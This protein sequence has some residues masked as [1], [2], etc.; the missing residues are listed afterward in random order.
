MS[1]TVESEKGL[2]IQNLVEGIMARPASIMYDYSEIVDGRRVNREHGSRHGVLTDAILREFADNYGGC[3]EKPVLQI[4]VSGVLV[5]EEKD[6]ALVG[7]RK[8]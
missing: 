5:P 3:F 4:S 1:A 7:C 2:S 6:W 8:P